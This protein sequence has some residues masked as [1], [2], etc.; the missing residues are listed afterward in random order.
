MR[1]GS[2]SSLVLALVIGYVTPM[3][4]QA[5]ARYRSAIESG[6]MHEIE[7][8]LGVIE[9]R[10]GDAGAVVAEC[11]VELGEVGMWL[12]RSLEVHGRAMEQSEGPA[13]P[14][15]QIPRYAPPTECFSIRAA[16]PRAA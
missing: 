10:L 6:A 3:P 2:F 4:S 13:S 9:R 1:L 11:L 5:G 12:A 7:H 15:K 14:P 16:R 8:T